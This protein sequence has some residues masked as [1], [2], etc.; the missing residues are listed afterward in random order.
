MA[1]G[2]LCVA[3]AAVVQS[4]VGVLHQAAQLLTQR[5]VVGLGLLREHTS[6]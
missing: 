5:G 4:G 1:E 2:L 6:Q 3:A